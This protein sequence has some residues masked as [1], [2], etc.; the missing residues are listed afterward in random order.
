[1]MRELTPNAQRRLERAPDL[2]ARSI[3]ARVDRDDR[4]ARYLLHRALLDRAVAAGVLWALA[5]GIARQLDVLHPGERPE[6]VAVLSEAELCE[7]ARDAGGIAAAYIAAGC[8]SDLPG[9]T[10]L[11]RQLA[12]ITMA[13]RVAWMLQGVIASLGRRIEAQG[14]RA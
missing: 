8:N 3:A 9:A 13:L 4:T 6:R 10:A 7:S 12:D 11:F 5:T 2:L 14:E 1:M